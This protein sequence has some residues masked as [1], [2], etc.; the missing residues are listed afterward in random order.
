MKIEEARV[1]HV[2]IEVLTARIDRWRVI[3]TTG[4]MDEDLLGE[5]EEEIP[6]VIE[7]IMIVE[8]HHVLIGEEIIRHRR[9]DVHLS[10]DQGQV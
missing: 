6:H 3:V 9:E 1:H 10:G 5:I 4:E 2:E 7:E 8:L